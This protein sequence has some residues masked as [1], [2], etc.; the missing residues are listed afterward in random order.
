M[1]HPARAH[2]HIT[3][4]LDNLDQQLE[5]NTI[6]IAKIVEMVPSV[7]RGLDATIEEQLKQLQS[8]DIK[9][10]RFEADVA[11]LKQNLDCFRDDNER[12][13]K[14]EIEH[15]QL[16]ANFEVEISR[17]QKKKKKPMWLRVMTL[18]I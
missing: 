11:H 6:T 5:M 17:I 1:Q 2:N 7:I 16:I 13:R 8:N 14:I 10:Q 18:G 15:K 9:L 4:A 12:L 3:V